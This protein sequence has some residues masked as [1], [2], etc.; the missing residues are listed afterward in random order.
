[1]YRSRWYS[2]IIM[3]CLLNWHGLCSKLNCIEIETD[4]NLAIT[5]GAE[6]RTINTTDLN[7]KRPYMIDPNYYYQI[8][9]ELC[10]NVLSNVCTARQF[11]LN[12]K[13]DPEF[14]IEEEIS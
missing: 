1:M 5:L 12:Y 4:K 2:V 7:L 9:S 3:L 8:Q 6:C 14:G 10:Q 13:V 11:N